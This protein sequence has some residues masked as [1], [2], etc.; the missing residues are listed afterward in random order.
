M[1]AHTHTRTCTHAPVGPAVGGQQHPRRLLPTVRRHPRPRPCLHPRAVR[2]HQHG[3]PCR[4]P[5]RG[6]HKVFKSDASV[7][8]FNGDLGRCGGRTVTVTVTVT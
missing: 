3:A 8:I 5:A 7:R 2:G 1:H 4:P 6:A